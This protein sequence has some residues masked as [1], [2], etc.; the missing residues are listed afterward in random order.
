MLLI[1][2]KCENYDLTLM[3]ASTVI[4]RNN[5]WTPL[6]NDTQCIAR[7]EQT[8]WDR[9]TSQSSVYI[10][11]LHIQRSFDEDKKAMIAKETGQ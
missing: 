8:A 1:T 6:L 9:E 3:A 4:M 10:F 11:R 7:G 5:S 2:S